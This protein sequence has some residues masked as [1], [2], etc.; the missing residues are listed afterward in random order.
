MIRCSPIP[1]KGDWRRSHATACRIA[2]ELARWPDLARLSYSRIVEDVCERFRVG[3]T[4][5]AIA[6][7]VFRQHAVSLHSS[8]NNPTNGAQ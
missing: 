5:A 8:D 1:P 7:R 3:K 2:V 4:T 6:V